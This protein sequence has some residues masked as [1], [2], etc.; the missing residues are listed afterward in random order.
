MIRTLLISTTAAGLL[1]APANVTKEKATPIPQ[2]QEFSIKTPELA[3]Y[4][5]VGIRDTVI[6]KT[7]TRVVTMI[8]LPDGEKVLDKFV[9]DPE[10]WDVRAIVNMMMIKPANPKG[11]TNLHVVAASG[12]AYTFV[13][14]A[15]DSVEPDFKV[16]L[17]AS[18]ET[19][20][21]AIHGP[22]HLILAADA[23]VYKRAAQ[24]WQAEVAQLKIDQAAQL[25]KVRTEAEK[26]AQADIPRKVH[27]DYKVQTGKAPFNV[28]G[29]WHDGTWSYIKARPREAFAVYEL[30]DDK[31]NLVN[32]QLRDGV[33]VF[34]K[35]IGDG[36]MQVGKAKQEF[37]RI[38]N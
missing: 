18:E 36:Y 8:V 28:S 9:G 33:Y 17:E 27:F 35:V 4:V 23:E 34:E 19:M 24:D 3:R 31:P 15:D 32:F 30:L 29:M 13:L 12:N 7:H 10:Y 37:K 22:Q 21:T 5:Q 6:I 16:F 26:N 11:R 14:I 25:Q 20:R 2:P 38:E 1:A